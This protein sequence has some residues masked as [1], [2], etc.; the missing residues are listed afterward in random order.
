MNQVKSVLGWAWA[1]K[2]TKSSSDLVAY[3]K[4]S[5]TKE[6]IIHMEEGKHRKATKKV[7]I[8]MGMDK[9]IRTGKIIFRK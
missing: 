1:D 9:K 4:G 3:G 7:F 6:K 8:H 2:F 5:A